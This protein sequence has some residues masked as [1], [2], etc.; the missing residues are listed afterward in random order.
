MAGLIHV[1]TGDGKGKT[2]AAAGLCARARGR[3]KTV[4][5]SQ[6]L[7]SGVT[8]EVASLERLGALVIR[9]DLRFGF[10]HEMDAETGAACR[11][12]QERLFSRII[13]AVREPAADLLVLD[14][15]LDAMNAGM[16]EERLLRS[17]LEGRNADL[18]VVITGR[19][20]GAW[21]ME[22]ADYVSDVRKVKHPFDRGVAARIGIER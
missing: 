6:F 17:F 3:D 8:G 7:K 9:S 16:L 19:R 1:Y 12:E 11:E 20:P 4:V 5:F 15:V 22:M 14:E 18:E 10:T 2:T 21:L 13:A